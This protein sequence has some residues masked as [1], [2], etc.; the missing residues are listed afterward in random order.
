LEGLVGRR[1]EGEEIEQLLSRALVE[2][3]FRRRSAGLPAKTQLLLLVAAA[4]PT[5]EAALLWRAT[6]HLGI[7]REA[8]A[9]AEQAGLV[10][11]GARSASATRWCARRSTGR[12]HRPTGVARTA[13]W[14]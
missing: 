9:P 3:G 6:T 10:E 1:A 12:P 7:A 4:D 5:G 11:I 14:P 13:R 2:D 8:V